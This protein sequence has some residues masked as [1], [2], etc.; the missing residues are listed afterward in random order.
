LTER[1]A[2]AFVDALQTTN[3]EVVDSVEAQ[4]RLRE[5]GVDVD[6]LVDDL[7]SYQT[8]RHHLKEHGVDTS[9]THEVRPEKEVDTILR[10]QHRLEK[11]SRRSIQRSNQVGQT[12]IADPMVSAA[13]T[14]ECRG[15]GGGMDTPERH[16]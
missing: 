11:V 7:T 14:V 15:C 13:V 3:N 2:E 9:R 1:E 16:R 4:T 12:E 8:I 6:D 5:L 10:L